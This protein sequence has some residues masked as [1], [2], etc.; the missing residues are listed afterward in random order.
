MFINSLTVPSSQ[1][2]SAEWLPPVNTGWQMNIFFLWL[3]GFPL[4]AV[5]SPRKL[6]RLEWTWF[7][8]FGFLALWGERYVIWFVFIL[9]V[10]TAGHAGGLGEK[11]SGPV[12]A[13]PAGF[14][15][16]AQP[17]VRAPA[18][19]LPAR[20][21][22]NVVEASPGGDG[23]H[24]HGCNRLAGGPSRTARPAVERD[25]LLQLPRICPAAAA[26]LDRHTLRSLPGGTMAG[27]QGYY[28]C[29]L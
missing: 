5:L 25:R 27:L 29:P 10:L 13:E 21:A 19:G 22:R 8:G 14:Q 23:K 1:L 15:P 3:L 9:V 11:I 16:G 2:F 4:L 12:E 7:L 18:A 26:H 20:P 24:A 28:R 17:A 6:D